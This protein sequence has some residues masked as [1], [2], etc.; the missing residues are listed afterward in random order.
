MSL[1]Y[2]VIFLTPVLVNGINLSNV[3]ND[4]FGI[5]M[6]VGVILGSNCAT[7]STFLGVGIS[8]EK[9]NYHFIKSL[10]YPF[11]KFL[12]QKFLV[13]AALQAFVPAMVYLIVGA[14]LLK[15]K[16]LLIFGF[17]LGLLMMISIQGQ[18]IYWRD[19]KNLNLLW[20]DVTQLFNRHSGQWLAFAIMMVAYLLGGGLAVG[21]VTLGNIT[22]Q[23]LLIN[24]TLAIV[25]LILAIV[26]QVLI[27]H[28]FWKKISH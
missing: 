10:P 14:F 6:L 22:Q 15:L 1:I 8:L 25:L 5:S 16:P 21:L 11:K 12:T 2:V 9:E 19:Y 13:L 28:K 18:L 4:Y 20:Q 27:S 24:M 23:I 3:P 7:P 26:G 17:L